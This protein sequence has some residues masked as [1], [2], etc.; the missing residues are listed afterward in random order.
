[1]LPSGLSRK[2]GTDG[3]HALLRRIRPVHPPPCISR[4]IGRTG[5]SPVVPHFVNTAGRRCTPVPQPYDTPARPRHAARQRNL[6]R[7]SGTALLVPTAER[8]EKATARTSSE[9]KHPPNC[10]AHKDKSQ[11]RGPFSEWSSSVAGGGLK[12]P[13]FGL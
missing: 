10:F 4:R 3:R 11:K 8:K 12:P 13:T 7:T 2:P 5:R 1:G 9:P 6:P